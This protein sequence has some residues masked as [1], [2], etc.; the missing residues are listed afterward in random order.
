[1]V[2][3]TRLHVKIWD[4]A[5]DVYQVPESVFPR[6][7]SSGHTR[8][9]TDDSELQFSYVASP[10]LFAVHRK[11]NGEILF[12]TSGSPLIFESQYLRL[13]TS[14]PMDP[15]LY[16]LGE[17][18]DHFRLNTTNYTRTLWSH[19]AYGIPPGNNLYGNHPV[20]YDHRGD[21][22]TSGT[23]LLNSDGMDIKINTTD[24]GQYLEYNIIGGIFDFY[25]VS[26]P[27]PVEAAQQYSEISGKSVMMPYWGH[28]VCQA[29]FSFYVELC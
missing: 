19:D 8:R 16:G 22:G 15:N 25:F 18:S 20:Y 13:R 1:M 11:S 29:L 27:S 10:F 7:A 4:T 23:F 9:S 2:K 6:P 17:N 3:A 24:S 12:N 28:G 26:G 5:G 14:L 21:R